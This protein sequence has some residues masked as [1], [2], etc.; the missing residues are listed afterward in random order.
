MSKV[1]KALETSEWF[2]LRDHSLHVAASVYVQYKHLR[3]VLIIMLLGET[4]MRVGELAQ[5]KQSDLFVGGEV[6]YSL[7]VRAEISKSKRTRFIPLT[8]TVQ[9]LLKELKRLLKEKN[10]F[11]GNCFVF[12]TKDPSEHITIRQI[13]RI[14]RAMGILAINQKLHPHMLRHTFA[15]RAMRVSSTRVVQQLLGH[16]SLNSTQI[17]THPNSTDLKDAIGK[18]SDGPKEPEA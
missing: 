11:V 7:N 14:V 3:D 12:F 15:T 2:K 13:E 16:K 9:E 4:G 18:M 10:M 1:I 6:V 8:E 17:Y 5:L